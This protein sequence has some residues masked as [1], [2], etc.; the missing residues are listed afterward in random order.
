MA[1]PKIPRITEYPVEIMIALLD[2][3]RLKYPVKYNTTRAGMAFKL[4]ASAAICIDGM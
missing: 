2:K 3:S 1:V 4:K